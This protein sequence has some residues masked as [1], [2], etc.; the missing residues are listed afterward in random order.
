MMIIR[1]LALVI[2]ISSSASAGFNYNIQCKGNGDKPNSMILVFAVQNLNGGLNLMDHLKQ[3]TPPH[4]SIEKPT[5]Y[6]ITNVELVKN[7]IQIEGNEQIGSLPS[8]T[9]AMAK[10]LVMLDTNVGLY[11][12]SYSNGVVRKFSLNCTVKRP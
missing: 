10:L 4:T 11:E 2:M 8:P 3:A 7:S 1:V 12:K 5:M 6:S 9:S